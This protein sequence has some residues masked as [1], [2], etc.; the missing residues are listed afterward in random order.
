MKKTISTQIKKDVLNMYNSGISQT[1]IAV[2][3]GISRRSVGRI[4]NADSK[5]IRC[6]II[7]LV[8][9]PLM[10]DERFQQ[11]AAEQKRQRETAVNGG[12]EVLE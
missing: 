8:N 4:I 7:P 2:V 1:E 12:T 10:S 9:I 5:E 3:C 11:I 6:R